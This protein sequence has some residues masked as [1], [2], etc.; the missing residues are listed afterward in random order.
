MSRPRLSAYV[1]RLRLRVG[2]KV[3]GALL[4][5]APSR[6]LSTPSAAAPFEPVRSYRRLQPG[7]AKNFPGGEFC[8]NW[9]GFRHVGQS[10]L[11]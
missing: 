11:E 4:P 3:I 7:Q 10:R 1:F 2:S 6:F 5:D 8:A 9:L